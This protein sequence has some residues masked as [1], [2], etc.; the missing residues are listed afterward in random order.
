[1]T[2]FRQQVR[3]HPVNSHVQEIL[4]PRADRFRSRASSSQASIL[5]RSVARPRYHTSIIAPPIVAAIPGTDLAPQHMLIGQQEHL[6]NED[7]GRQREQAQTEDLEA[8]TQQRLHP[9]PIKETPEERAYD[10]EVSQ[11]KNPMEAFG[12]VKQT[13]QDV[14]PVTHE[15]EEMEYATLRNQASNGTLNPEQQS[16]VE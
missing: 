2:L 15:Q 7:F 10:Y 11:G 13:A 6:A 4:A 9:P 8:Q 12:E 16:S 14:K 1:M 3:H 5:G